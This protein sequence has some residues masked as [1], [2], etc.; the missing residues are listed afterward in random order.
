MPILMAHREVKCLV[1][2]MAVILATEHGLL[3]N[4]HAPSA[5]LQADRAI[6]DNGDAPE[7]RTGRTGM[8]IGE[9]EAARCEHRG[10]DDAQAEGGE[11]GADAAPVAAPEGRELEGSE[12]AAGEETLG[13]EVGGRLAEDILARVQEG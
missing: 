8:R 1:R 7:D 2:Y 11:G 6:R 5:H 12:L 3:S 13:A 9:S 4:S 10:E